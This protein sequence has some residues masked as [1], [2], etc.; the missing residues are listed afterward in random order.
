MGQFLRGHL[1]DHFVRP[2]STYHQM[3]LGTR[4][5]IYGLGVGISMAF[6]I[7]QWFFYRYF[8]DEYRPLPLTRIT[9]FFPN[10]HSFFPPIQFR[11]KK[12][13]DSIPESRNY[14]SRTT[15]QRL[16]WSSS[17]KLFK[18]CCNNALSIGIQAFLKHWDRSW[19]HTNRNIRE[20]SE[21]QTL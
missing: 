20:E 3:L 14:L 19:C 6:E 12:K 18:Y 2:W 1:W 7:Y 8:R 17:F 21:N 13:I 11:V 16:I 5:N 9:H 15:W 10:E 4:N